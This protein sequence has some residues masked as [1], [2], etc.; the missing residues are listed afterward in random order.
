MSGELPPKGQPAPNADRLGSIGRATLRTIFAYDATGRVD[1]QPSSF[2]VFGQSVLPRW[3]IALLVAS[4]LLP[5]LVASIDS[6][7]RVRRRREPVTPW[8]RWLAAGAVPFLL[9]WALAEFLTLVG[10][11]PDT[12]PVPLSPASFTVAPKAR[13]RGPPNASGPFASKSYGT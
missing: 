7:A 1:E 3:S 5:V 12:P 2:L 6:F 13:S 8:L 10:Q 11:A 9:A 4:L